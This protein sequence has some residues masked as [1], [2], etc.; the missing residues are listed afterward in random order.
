MKLKGIYKI[1]NKIN[2]KV[3]IGSSNNIP[4]RWA[5]HIECLLKGIHHNKL[6]QEDFNKYGLNNFTFEILET[7]VDE[8]ISKYDLL[9]IETETILK[10]KALD[11]SIGYNLSLPTMIKEVN[12][13][14]K[15]SM[16]HTVDEIDEKALEKIIK[17]I[18]IHNIGEIKRYSENYTKLFSDGFSHSWF[19]K[20]KFENCEEAKKIM[21]NWIRNVAKVKTGEVYWTTYKDVKDKIQSKGFIKSFVGDNEVKDEKRNTLAYMMRP[22]INP[23]IDDD[24]IDYNFNKKDYDL[25]NLIL[26]VNSVADIDKP[27]DILIANTSL[28]KKVEELKLTYGGTR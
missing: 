24:L 15:Y 20:N 19:T 12:D 1:E 13:E 22:S 7:Y 9:K 16:K 21:Y 17:N 4:K 8:A 23:F 28:I 14:N 2:K 6:L 11:R 26:W 3:Y 10:Y 25:I 5:S 18:R 27:I